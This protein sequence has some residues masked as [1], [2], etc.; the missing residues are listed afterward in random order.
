[1]LPVCSTHICC[2]QTKE[3]TITIEWADV[4]PIKHDKIIDGLT[5][6]IEDRDAGL[7]G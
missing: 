3:Q 6:M 5:R 2:H 7:R 4:R 1:M